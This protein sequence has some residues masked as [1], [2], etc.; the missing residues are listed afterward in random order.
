MM[1]P[2]SA[3]LGFSIIREEPVRSAEDLQSVKL[4]QVYQWW[5]D[6]AAAGLPQRRSFDI[7]SHREVASQVCL[8]GVLPDGTFQPRIVGHRMQSWV[9]PGREGTI[10]S[11]ECTAANLRW[12]FMHYRRVAETRTAWVNTGKIHLGGTGEVRYE[13]LDCPVTDDGE[14]V[15]AIVGI[16]DLL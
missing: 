11:E 1:I 12:L 6:N 3:W 14:T 15:S 7:A 8:V 2:R 16:L 5:A 10:I 4:R 9:E 13:G